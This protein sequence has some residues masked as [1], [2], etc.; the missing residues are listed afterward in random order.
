[1]PRLFVP[2]PTTDTTR[3]DLP[4]RRNSMRSTLRSVRPA[5]YAQCAQGVPTARPAV[6]VLHDE[7]DGAGV[8][9]LEQPGAVRLLL[10]PDEFDRLGHPLVRWGAGVAEVVERAQGVVVP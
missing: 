9:V 4:R 10:G 2:S 5:Q 1:M 8:S 7:V 3:P 6:T